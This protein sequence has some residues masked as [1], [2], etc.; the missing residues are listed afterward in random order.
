M[1]RLLGRGRPAPHDPVPS[2][3]LLSPWVFEALAT[4]KLRQR[5]LAAACV[6]VMLVGA[7]WS[8]QHLRT[9]QAEQVLVVEQ[10]ETTRLTTQTNQLAPVRTYVATVAQQKVTVS[11]SMADEVYLSRVLAG[12][13]SATPSGADVETMAITVTPPVAAAAEG[14]AEAAVVDGATVSA[15]PG[16]DPFNTRVVVGCV[17]LSGT[18]S[19]RATVGDL[20]LNLGEDALFVEPFIST[21]TTAEGDDVVFTGSVGLS[22]RAFTGRYAEIDALLEK[23]AGR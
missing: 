14:E 13:R 12:M 16:P 11:E 10:A 3:N 1:S 15:C 17:T 7:G 21:T 6:L 4:R 20:V 22:T 19:S 8:V 2:V 9:R 18:A 23:E 5:F